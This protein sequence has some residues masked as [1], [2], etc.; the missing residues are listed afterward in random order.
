[1]TAFQADSFNALIDALLSANLPVL[2]IPKELRI[3]DILLR[4]Q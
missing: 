2:V 4:E 3:G 1:M